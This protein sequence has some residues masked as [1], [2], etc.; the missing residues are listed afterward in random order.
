MPAALDARCRVRRSRPSYD[1]S[2][3]PAFVM[4]NPAPRRVLVADDEPAVRRLL[5]HILEARGFEA[6]LA[7]SGREAIE[8][9]DRDLACALVDLRMPELDGFAVLTQLQRR[10]PRLPV[11]I[12]SAVAEP[13]DV[14]EA[15]AKGAA[16]FLA[17]PFDVERLMA[18]VT[19]LAGPPP[20]R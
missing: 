19:A 17:K 16:E 11:V 12:M 7:A 20:P 18:V 13:P 5:Q 8:R 10:Q 3:P 9:A 4:A 2:L 14:A 6:V 15:R 1:E